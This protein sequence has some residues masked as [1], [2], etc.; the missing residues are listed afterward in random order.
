VEATAADWITAAFTVVLAGFTAALVVVTARYVTQTRNLVSETQKSRE[1][2]RLARELS[3][4][5]KLAIDLRFHG[6]NF[7]QVQVVNVGPGPALGVDIHIAFE[8]TAESQRERQERPWQA[9]IVV[10]ED[11]PEFDPPDGDPMDAFAAAYEQVR[12]TGSMRSV[13][14]ETYDIDEVLDDLTG[15]W[16]RLQA[17][18]QVLEREPIERLTRELGKPLDKGVKEL[19]RAR[20]ALERLAPA[21]ERRL[22]GTTGGEA[23]NRAEAER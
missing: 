4:R 22:R 21:P 17:S 19:H 6:P 18:E 20:Q 1:E 12:L 13:S 2:S 23:Q 9:N 8:P 15:R 14:G 10:S 11:G 7:A 5:P 16:E 3:V